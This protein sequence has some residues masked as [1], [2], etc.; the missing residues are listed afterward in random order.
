MFSMKQEISL[1]Y[2][3]DVKDFACQISCQWL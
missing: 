3:K 1:K 2:G